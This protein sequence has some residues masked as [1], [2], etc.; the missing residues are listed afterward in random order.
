MA[1][2]MM[3]VGIRRQT[4]RGGILLLRFDRSGACAPCVRRLGHP[5]HV[6]REGSNGHWWEMGK[7]GRFT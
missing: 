1:R 7:V 6:K 4:S 3:Q 2:A 5:F